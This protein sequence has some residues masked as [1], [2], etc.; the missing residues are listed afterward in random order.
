MHM[1]RSTALHASSAIV[2]ATLAALAWGLPPG[3]FY[4]GDSGVK[5]IAARN[6]L[7]RPERPLEIPL[8]AIGGE[9]LPHVEP[10]FAVHEDHSHAATSELFPIISAP[11]LD[12]FGLRGLYVIP[13]LAG[14]VSLVAWCSIAITLDAARSPLFTFWSLILASPLLFYSLEFWEHAPAFAV[15][16]LAVLLMTRASAA[17]SIAPVLWAGFAFG[18]SSLLRPE[19]ALFGISWL[20]SMHLTHKVC[21]RPWRFAS[22]AVAGAV[23]AWIPLGLYN[24][25][26][27]GQPFGWHVASNSLLF[28]DT[29]WFVSRRSL[30]VSWFFSVSV[31]N[32]LLVTPVVALA[33]LQMARR[34]RFAS[35][36][37]LACTAAVYT[38]LVCLS[39]PNDGGAQW[40]PRYL[41]FA[42]GPV[43]VLVGDSAQRL[44]QHRHFGAAILIVACAVLA[45]WCQRASYKS[46]R[47]TKMI[48][49]RITAFVGNVAP[50]GSWVVTDLWW[51]DQVTASLTARTFLYGGTSRELTAVLDRLAKAEVRP[52]IVVNAGVAGSASQPVAPDGC[53]LIGLKT[54][55]D[56]HLIATTLACDER[57]RMR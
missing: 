35:S 6:A 57:L 52:V 9:P 41:L 1:S 40:A 43:C 3:S 56:R 51:L 53:A 26:H 39:A 48:Y 31:S 24:L 29:D 25:L 2:A 12:W 8:P 28:S 55:A 45:L 15:V 32:A 20:M 37:L 5:L 23:A 7:D 54:H 21:R 38:L 44:R 14:L 49:G 30:L 4:S 33:L 34:Y 47:T 17:D 50:P 46:L 18:I 10:F 19:A 27:F 11:L 42:Y 13:L 22:G 16:S 36:D